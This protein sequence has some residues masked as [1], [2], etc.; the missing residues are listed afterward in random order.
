MILVGQHE[1]PITNFYGHP[2]SYYCDHFVHSK[3][4]IL[5]T[6]MYFPFTTAKNLIGFGPEHEAF[7]THMDRLQM[8]LVLAIDRALARNRVSVD[9]RGNPRVDY[10]LTDEVL[11]SL[12]ASMQVCT[13]IFFAAG[14]QCVHAPASKKFAIEASERDRLDK[15]IL[16]NQLKPGKVSITSAHLMGGCRMGSNPATSVTNAWGEVHGVPWLFVADA[17]LFPKCSEVNPYLTI[18]ALADRVAQRVRSRAR[19]LLAA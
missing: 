6:C 15:L 1:R 17:S 18:M 14:A 19:A 7:L 12:Y 3:R 10:R 5:E 16:R 4:F 13:Q 8:I 9:R 11:D 2:K